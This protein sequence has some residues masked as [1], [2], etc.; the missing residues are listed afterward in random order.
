MANPPELWAFVLSN[1]GLFVVSITLTALSYHTYRQR[2]RQTSY[3]I[4]TV[5]FGFVVLGG[6]VEPI[7][8]LVLRGDYHI[9]GAELLFLQAGETLLIAVGL[10]ALFYAITHHKS[11]SR[12]PGSKQTASTTQYT[13]KTGHQEN[14]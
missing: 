1:I 3:Q 14:D 11:R 12:L 13:L 10:G 7:Y 4:A 8:Q 9:T 5:G 2:G 6:L